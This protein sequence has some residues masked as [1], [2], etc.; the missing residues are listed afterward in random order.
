MEMDKIE[1]TT[2]ITLGK[3][4]IYNQQETT[5][6]ERPKH[7]DHKKTDLYI[8][9]FNNKKLDD[10][11]WNLVKEL[12]Q[13]L[14]KISTSRRSKNSGSLRTKDETF[15]REIMKSKFSTLKDITTIFALS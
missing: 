13:V 9:D 10:R 3:K 15:D 14:V 6:V 8:Q 4:V 7:V 5:F 2:T 11:Q 12:A 1:T